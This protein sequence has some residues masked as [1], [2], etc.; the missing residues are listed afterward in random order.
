MKIRKIV[1]IGAWIMVIFLILL[2]ISKVA[3]ARPIDIPQEDWMEMKRTDASRPEP[4]IIIVE[5]VIT[6]AVNEGY[7]CEA[8]TI[9]GVVF[10]VPDWCLE[11]A[12]STNQLPLLP[13][14]SLYCMR[15]YMGPDDEI[16]V[17]PAFPG[18][19]KVDGW[20]LCS[21]GSW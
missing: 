13:G 1:E 10:W 6:P 5:P 8:S 12:I 15:G 19:E 2:L 11:R 21:E 4:P 18:E 16:T 14:Q 3:E 7:F 17:I 9:G 20:P